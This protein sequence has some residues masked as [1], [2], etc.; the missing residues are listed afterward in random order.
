MTI[1]PSTIGTTKGPQLDDFQDI[2][3]SLVQTRRQRVQA[4]RNREAQTGVASL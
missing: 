3:R 1:T 2:F 4:K